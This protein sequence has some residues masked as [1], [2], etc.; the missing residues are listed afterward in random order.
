[1]SDR[2]ARDCDRCWDVLA[3]VLDIRVLTGL[4]TLVFFRSS[5]LTEF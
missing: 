1:M 3:V 5:S 4:R 2:I